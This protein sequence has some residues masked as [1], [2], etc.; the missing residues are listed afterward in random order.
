MPDLAFEADPQRSRAMW[1]LGA[2]GGVGTTTTA[3]LA[4][5]HVV[6]LGSNAVIVDPRG[7][8][9]TQYA[10]QR[11]TPDAF[12]A[13]KL[14]IEWSI[15]H[16]E[17]PAHLHEIAPGIEM[18][19]ARGSTSHRNNGQTGEFPE[20]HIVAAVVQGAIATG[21]TVIVDLGTHRT[22]K[23][24]GWLDVA[25]R[26]D[27]VLVAANS[28]PAIRRSRALLDGEHVGGSVLYRDPNGVHNPEPLMSCN[29]K[30]DV[31]LDRNPLIAALADSAQLLHSD[32]LAE[33]AAL[34][35]LVAPLT[36]RHLDSAELQDS[37]GI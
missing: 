2:A 17:V 31:V 19:T 24:A 20:P 11:G 36:V 28:I 37:C 9:V 12:A 33:T 18:L 5:K 3:L 23:A 22:A 21:A 8:L 26:S 10:P 34:G 13:M 6:E 1:L 25:P 30:L 16:R 14:H 32:G 7:D 29:G 4:A 15:A 27:R 35:R